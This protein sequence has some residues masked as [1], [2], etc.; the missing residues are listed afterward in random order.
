VSDRVVQLH[1]GRHVHP[2]Y[3]DQL[4]ALP[5][6]WEY[7]HTHPALRSESTPTKKIVEQSERFSRLRAA[8]ERAALRVLSFGGYVH[9]VRAQ[10]VPGTRLIHSAERLLRNPA[11]PYVVDLE[12]AD[13]FTLYQQA[14]WDRPWTRRI[15]ERALCD[16]RLRFLLPWSDAARRSVLTVLSEEARGTV[17]SKLRTVYMAARLAAER[18]RERASG[19]LRAL[20]IGTHF[21]EKGGMTALRALRE[22]RRTHEVA[23]DMVTYPPQDLADELASE[24][25]L[26]LHRPAGTELVRDLYG[27]S[28]ILLFPSH[29]DTYGVAVGEAM[30]HG[31]PVVAP[32]HLA[33]TELVRDEE[34]GL[35]FAP[36]NMLWR[37]DTRCRF[38]HTLPVPTGYLRD[39]RR[40]SEPFVLGVAAALARLAED[41]G[42][43]D[44]LSGG[45]LE[46]VR[47]GRL[48]VA[49][50]R[51]VL[52]EIY[53]SAAK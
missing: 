10:P 37:E 38:R 41:S 33:L 22:V 46:T 24:P 36:E 27:K 40:P 1:F 11:T 48:S 16:E 20:F 34:S 7:A 6:G 52:G 25:G 51:E 44:R 49:R 39:L 18:P 19:A 26:T 9:R 23:L 32:R 8:G 30:G 47:S 35:L 15:V 4:L 5:E 28:D 2:V 12:H 14:S 42:L 43:Y 21:V 3:R 13:V 17:E 31:L 53:G 50:R 45:A 29:M